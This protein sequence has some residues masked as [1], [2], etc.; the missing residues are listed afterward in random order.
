M[1]KNRIGI[2]LSLLLLIGFTSCTE[3][4]SNSKLVIN[5]VLVDNQTNFQDDYGVH[6]G[7]I[8]IFN[9]A[10]S[11]ADLAGCLLKVS[12]QPGDTVTYFIPKGDVL[13]SIKPR[14]HTLFWADG[15]PRRGTFHTNFVLSKTNANWIGL[16]DS[17][18][19]LL[20]QVVVP[21]GILA[22][23]QSYARVGDASAE[24]EVK[25]ASA[26]K[27]VTPSTNNQTIES[28]P[29]MDKFEQHDPVGIGMAISAMSVVF[30]GLILLYICFKLIGKAAIKLRKRNAMIAHNI[31]DK[32]EAQE[33]KL[34]EAPGEVIAAISM[35]L[36]EA[37][38][39]DH[40]VEET[41]LTISRVKRSYSPWSSKI[42]TLRETPHKK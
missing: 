41:I 3:Q 35:A 5:E 36:H 24:W 27:Y 30:L 6:S 23:N 1:R 19:K 18:K 20:D 25:G 15:N 11:T 28:N 26:D 40:D 8:E 7:W 13:T 9:K 29:K 33:K 14:Q 42:Y 22:A 16:Y 31:T 38:G 34:G 39:A 37:Q 17:G 2:F 4:K 21:A 32:Q 10:Y 12:S